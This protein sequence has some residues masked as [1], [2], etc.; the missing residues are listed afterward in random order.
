MRLRSGKNQKHPITFCGSIS[1][2]CSNRLKQIAI[3]KPDIR[4]RDATKAAPTTE[5]P[6]TPPDP[7]NF[8]A[9]QTKTAGEHV[10]RHFETGRRTRP[11]FGA[12][13]GG[14]LAALPRG[15]SPRSDQKRG[16]REFF[17]ARKFGNFFLFFW[18]FQEKSFQMKDAEE[19]KVRSVACSGC[20][21][22]NRQKCVLDG[23]P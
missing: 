1:E 13:V 2:L 17:E 9:F 12:G 5:P 15:V 4:A 22:V 14:A 10:G 3:I 18:A 8:D 7:S 21:W 16:R 19:N 23:P 6:L 11:V 20:R